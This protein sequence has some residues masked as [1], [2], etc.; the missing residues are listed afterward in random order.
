MY[1]PCNGA[2]LL[3]LRDELPH[4]EGDVLRIALEPVIRSDQVQIDPRH[5]MVPAE[6]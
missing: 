1:A 6:P 2:A 4:M 3:T 5:L